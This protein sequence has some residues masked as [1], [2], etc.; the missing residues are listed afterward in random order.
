[1]PRLLHVLFIALAIPA[2]GF[3]VSTWILF[4]VD[5]DLAD[6]NIR[7]V[8]QICS[9][10]TI[11]SDQ[12]IR[13]F[14]ESVARIRA[15]RDGSIYTAGLGVGIPT[16]FWLAS[17]L[18]GKSRSRISVIFPVLVRLSTVLL[19]AMV[20]AQGAIFTYA[21][22][23]AESHLVGRVHAQLILLIGLGAVVG[24]AGLIWASVSL[25]PRL[26]MQVL[27]KRVTPESEPRLH[28]FVQAL[29][30]RLHARPPDN[31]IVGLD[32]TFF[33]TSADI[34]TPG[35]ILVGESLFVSTALSRLLSADEFTAVIGHE[36]GHFRGSDTQYSM[37]FA[38]IYAGLSKATGALMTFK[39]FR[40]LTGIPALWVLS[41]MRD[42]F[43]TNERAIGRERE[44]IAD[45]TGAEASS[46]VALAISLVKISTYS[47]LWEYVRSQNAKQLNEGKIDSNLGWVRLFSVRV[48]LA[49]S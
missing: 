23:L 27:G 12:A 17:A 20:L 33:V 26:Q 47:R 35:G 5:S 48:Y 13:A 3:A 6:D 24:A 34:R 36:L 32:P 43:A 28:S 9:P 7:S 29:S 30:V 42:V 14:C 10:A 21:V 19:A 37:R 49:H 44:F 45:T 18:A 40:A 1:M 22:W 11:R 41:Y 46:P 15:L 16:L 38:P 39:D 2:L 4:D 31:I 8:Q 25:T